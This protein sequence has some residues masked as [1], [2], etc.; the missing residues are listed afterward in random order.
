MITN[1]SRNC[2]ANTTVLRMKLLIKGSGVISYKLQW[3]RSQHWWHNY[4]DPDRSGDRVLFSID[5]FVLHFWSIPKN[6]AMSRCATRGRG[7]L[8]F[9]TT[10]C[11]YKKAV[12]SQRW[13][14][15]APVWPIHGWPEIFGTPWLR[16]SLVLFPTFFM[17][18]CSDQSY[19]CS[20][21]IWSP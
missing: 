20:Y 3:M 16:P 14:R 8:C 5:F 11:L 12:L 15:N 6:R 2:T 21:K 1:N 17:G 19:E 4:P 13:P 9:S 7:L 18:F 10:A